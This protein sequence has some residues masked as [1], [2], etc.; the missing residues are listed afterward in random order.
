MDLRSLTNKNILNLDFEFGNRHGTF[1]G[2][3]ETNINFKNLEGVFNTYSSKLSKNN[4]FICETRKYS[5]YK[6][7]REIQLKPK[8]S[9]NL[10]DFVSRFTVLTKSKKPA[11][12]CGHK[13]LHKSSNI[14]Y[15]KKA[16]NVIIPINDKKSIIFENLTHD[17]N[18]GFD[19]VMYVRDECIESN[20]YKWVVHH[21][22]IA[23]NSN[24]VLIGC[25]RII[26]GEITLQN[27]VPKYLKKF[28]YRIREK[29]LPNFPFM[30]INEKIVDNNKPLNIKTKLYIKNER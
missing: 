15:Q 16:S 28:F 22:L 30:V 26:K 29:S 8:S 19:N 23:N 1:S 18:Q 7:I 3:S 9:I 5:N 11:E 21:R 20:F 24:F 25:N 13:I 14:Y 4:V 17:V 12:I 10:F 2:T 6:L 27:L